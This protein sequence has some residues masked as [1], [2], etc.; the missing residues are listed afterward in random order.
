M[1]VCTGC[2]EIGDVPKKHWFILIFP[3]QMSSS[4]S[5]TFHAAYNL[6]LPVYPMLHPISLAYPYESLWD[7]VWG[8]YIC[9]Y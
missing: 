3:L 5:I 4:P 8:V 1:Y 6:Y 9:L 2:P 7:H